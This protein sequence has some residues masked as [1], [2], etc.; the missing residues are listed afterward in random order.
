MISLE[1]VEA[2]VSGG[3]HPNGKELDRVP[4]SLLSFQNAARHAGISVAE[5]CQDPKKMAQAQIGYWEEFRHDLIDIENGIA[6]MA[7][8]V[9]C[10]VEYAENDAP[11]ITKPAIAT[12]DEVDRLRDVELGSTPAVKALIEATRIVAESLG[13][14]VCVR[15]EADQGPFDLACEIVGTE[16]FLMALFDSDLTDP[17]W[18]LLTYAQRQVEKLVLAQKAAGT[19]FTMVGESFAGPD[20]CSPALYK[21]YAFPFEKSLVER[22]QESGIGVG[23][24]ICGNAT[25]IIEDMVATGAPYFELDYKIDRPVVASAVQGKTAV[26][27]TVDPSGVLARGTPEEIREAVRSDVEFF[28]PDKRFVLSP[29]CT[30]PYSTPF[31][32]IRTFVEAG[33]EFGVY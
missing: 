14:E 3:T 24:H 26:F 28:A 10:T 30:L 27:G 17:V 15:G 5:Y 20:V 16:Q 1:R 23:I 22:M 31:E 32:N 8:A 2:A 19:H 13:R 29:G 11:W 6:A 7:E 18:K 25:A 9:G 33:R 12:L 21:Q 4:I